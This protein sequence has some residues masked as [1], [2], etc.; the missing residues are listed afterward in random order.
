M[1]RLIGT[2][3]LATMA[4]VSGTAGAQDSTTPTKPPATAATAP[5]PEPAGDAQELAKK[6]SNPIAALISVPFQSNF[7]FNIGPGDDGWKYQLNIQPVVPISI[8]EDWNVISRT[9]LPLVSQYDIFPGAGDQFGLG[10]ITQ[11]FFF[12]PKA[13]S[14][15]GRLIWGVGPAMLIPTATDDLL[16]TEKFG[17][18][19]TA[20]VLKQDGPWTLGML[21]NQI[22]SVAGDSDEP[23]RFDWVVEIDPY[24]PNSVPVK[25]TALGR[26]GHEAATS[27]INKDGRAV[28]YLGDDDYFEYVYKFVSRGTVNTSDRAANK[29]LLDD[30]TLHVGRFNADG[31]LD[32]LPLVFGQGPLTPDNGFNSQGDVVLQARK[33]GDLLGATPM[34]RPEDFEPNHANGRVYLVLTKNSKRKAEQVNAANTRAKN[35]TGHI[36]EL[37]PPGEGKDADHAAAQFKWDVF[38]LAGDPTAADQGAKYGEGASANGW[39]A[40]PDNIA[41]DPQ[42]RLWIATD[43]APDFGIADGLYATE[44]DGPGRAVP[45][46]MYAVPM[47]AEMCGPCFSPDGQ[48]LF[49]A[50]QHPAE[51]S[52][53]LEKATTRWPDFDEKVPPRP[54]VVTITREGGGEV[55]T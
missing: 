51:K 10:D 13:P 29:D 30:G 14:G 3:A 11:S 46:L 21:A 48:T 7:D 5:P 33:A 9:I 36:L 24:D 49:V 20:V 40:N 32:W 47:N 35:T 44:I 52:E 1:K 16:G 22:W 31:T 18:G 12:S 42:G 27:I 39:F 26:F 50:V 45:K 25:R 55:G 28:V 23:N 54:S 37:L 15:F 19:P 34:D 41:F 8:S 53:T 43:G 17:I 4:I 6:L 2:L 38:I